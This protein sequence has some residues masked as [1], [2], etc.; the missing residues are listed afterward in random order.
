MK[1]RVSELLAVVALLTVP[2][3]LGLL[4]YAPSAAVAAGEH[5]GQTVFMA[6]KCTMCHSIETLS[7]A[8][9]T[10]SDKMKGPDL[11]NASARSAEWTTKWIQRQEQIDGKT[12]KKEWKG[13]AQELTDLVAFLGTLKKG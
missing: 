7:I 11:S 13:S 12:H 8:A 2:L 6:Q 10:K 4:L 9:T 1:S 3:A 5:A